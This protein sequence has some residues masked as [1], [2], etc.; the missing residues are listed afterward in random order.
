MMD[1]QEKFDVNTIREDFPILK[2]E[3]NGKPL[4]YL[5]NGA[6]SQKPKM[7]ID[8]IS[9]YY[10][11]INSNV[12][13]G[14]HHLSQKATDAFEESRLAVKDFIGANTTEEVIF[15]SGTTESI[16]IIASSFGKKHIQEG[17][18][19]LISTMEHHSNIVP[20][21]L[22]CEEKGAVL[23]VIPIDDKGEI[24]LSQYESLLSDKT[25]IVAVSHISNSLGTINPIKEMIDIAHE[26]NIPVLIDGAQA[27]AHQ[28]IDVRE[29]D[30]D[31]YAF[32]LHKMFGPTGVGIL[33]GKKEL[34]D[35][36]PPYQGGG[37]MIK[38]VSF[39]KTTFNEL[40][41]K[42]EAGTPNIADIIATKSAIDYLLQLDRNGMLKHEEKLLHY[43]TD[44]L[45]AIEGLKIIGEATHKTSVIS[46]TVEGVHHYD[47]GV[48]LDKLGIAVRTGHHC[49]QPLMERYGI[50]GT[51][52]ASFA[53][54]NTLEEVDQLIEA[55]EKALKMLR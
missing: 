20:W 44:R 24:I 47:I 53:F 41:H 21:Q 14:V 9:N 33:Y 51:V 35:S 3:V 8:S 19:I 45:K 54:Y 11:E 13:R 30:C 52:R 43:A 4:V 46:F 1:V 38:T 12:H 42:F 6:S 55:L 10:N 48:I 16:N 5:D 15:T 40:P 31:F 23:K 25:K 22:L 18:E 50:S 2:R 7:V 32:S 34:L 39:E 17:D 28:T 49:T 29:L 26:K 27:V 37:E 36:L